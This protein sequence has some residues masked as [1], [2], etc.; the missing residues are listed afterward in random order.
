MYTVYTAS[1]YLLWKI[2][3]TICSN[4]FCLTHSSASISHEPKHR[5][6]KTLSTAAGVL[7]FKTPKLHANCTS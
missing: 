5:S 4:Y 3:Y 1:Q 2:A 7:L 6:W